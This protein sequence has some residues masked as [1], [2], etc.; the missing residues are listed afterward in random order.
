MNARMRVVL[1]SALFLGVAGFVFAQATD[2]AEHE[3]QINILHVA[4]MDLNDTGL[5]TLTTT[6]PGQAGDVFTGETDNTS[7]ELYYTLLTA[8][9]GYITVELTNPGG[10][11]D[12]T[13]PTGTA[14]WVEANSITV[15]G[16]GDGGTV[17]AGG[18]EPVLG[19]A[20]TI[21]NSI[22]SCYTGHAGGDGAT[23]EYRLVISDATQ[24]AADDAATLYVVFTLNSVL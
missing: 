21:I 7:K 20:G 9:D 3:V 12:T 5:L 14:F 22:G 18:V 23:L 10:L 6:D 1:L 11:Y 16:A 4:M 8:S 2:T 15:S 17:I 19:S 13:P 24:V